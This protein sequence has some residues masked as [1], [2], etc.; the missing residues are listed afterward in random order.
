[1]PIMLEDAEC[2]WRRP[3]LILS[4]N[5]RVLSWIVIFISESVWCQ[6]ISLSFPSICC[7]MGA[8]LLLLF[9]D[10]GLD[11]DISLLNAFSRRSTGFNVKYFQAWRWEGKYFTQ[12]LMA[13]HPDRRAD[14]LCLLQW[15]N[16]KVTLVRQFSSIYGPFPQFPVWFGTGRRQSAKSLARRTPWRFRAI[17]RFP[18]AC[19]KLPLSESST[20]PYLYENSGWS[21][22]KKCTRY[23]QD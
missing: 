19:R 16:A 1:M 6:A 11:I 13:S 4:P 18:R 12:S 21:L 5:W 10:A 15:I 9:S 8:F 14:S 17:S 2:N 7:M 3:A 22:G 20:G 23:Q